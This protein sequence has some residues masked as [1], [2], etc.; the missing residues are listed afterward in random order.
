[1][2]LSYVSARYEAPIV[3]FTFKKGAELGIPEIKE[4]ISTAEKLSAHTS[5]VVLS[6]SRAGVNV[7]HEGRKLSADASASPLHRGTATLVTNSMMQVAINFFFNVGQPKF[8]F[9]AFVEKEKA[10]EWLLALPL[11]K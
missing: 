3:Y 5:Y 1:M 8:P 6:D 2:E 10:I 11:E 7:T 4:L 9:R